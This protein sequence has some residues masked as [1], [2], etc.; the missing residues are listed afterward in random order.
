MYRQRKTWQEGKQ[1]TAHGKKAA[2]TSYS[3]WLAAIVFENICGV[4]EKEVSRSLGR[5]ESARQVGTVRVHRRAVRATAAFVGG[6]IGRPLRPVARGQCVACW[7]RTASRCVLAL[8]HLP[9]CATSRIVKEPSVERRPRP[10]RHG[11]DSGLG[12]FS[13]V[14]WSLLVGYT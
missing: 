12:G 13:R 8:I 3:R 1:Q 10:D 2:V 9:S 4:P 6:A 5:G 11:D 7:R 14:F